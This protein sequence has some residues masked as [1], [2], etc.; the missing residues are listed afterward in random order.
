MSAEHLML[1]ESCAGQVERNGSRFVSDFN[2]EI[3]EMAAAA[4]SIVPSDIHID[5]LA[6]MLSARDCFRQLEDMRDAPLAA[7]IMTDSS[8]FNLAANAM[9]R[10]LKKTLGP[11][12][13]AASREAWISAFRAIAEHQS[14]PA[15]A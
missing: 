13:T 3:C 12:M 15:N 5:P 2:H 9:L 1:V 6:F 8:R 7:D 10:A 14:A 11:D 4:P